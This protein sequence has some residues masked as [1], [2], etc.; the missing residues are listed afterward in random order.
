MKK[1]FELMALAAAL[2][3]RFDGLSAGRK[4][5]VRLNDID[6]TPKKPLVPKGCKEYFFNHLG[7]FLNK[8]D[9]LYCFK[10]IAISDKS[11]T[12]KFEKWVAR[13]GIVV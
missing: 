12:K 4:N 2:S 3:G 8:N 6:F 7:D 1:S 13:Q 10:C 11:A 9:G 5:G